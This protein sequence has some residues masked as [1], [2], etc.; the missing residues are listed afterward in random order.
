MRL[1][2]VWAA[3]AAIISLVVVGTPAFALDVD[4]ANVVK[5]ALGGVLVDKIFSDVDK[6]IANAINQVQNAGNGLVM[7]AANQAS[8][9]EQDA[10]LLVGDQRQKTFDQLNASEQNLLVEMEQWRRAVDKATG[11]AYDI[12]DTVNLDTSYQLQHLPFTNVPDFFV[13][14]VHGVSFLKQ[15]SDYRVTL[16]ALNLGIQSNRQAQISV[17][18]DQRPLRIITPDQ[19][20]L[21]RAIITIPSAALAPYFQEDHL[22][23]V[24]LVIRVTMTQ[25]GLLQE[26]LHFGSPPS[27]THEVPVT[28]TLYPALAATIALEVHYPHYDWISIGAVPGSPGPPTPDKNGCRNPASGCAY[29]GPVELRV[30]SSQSTPPVQGDQRINAYRLDCMT[31][32]S[33]CNFARV[34]SSQL[35]EN[36]SHAIMVY[37]TWSRPVQMR[38]LATAVSEYR[39]RA[40]DD[41]VTV[42][43]GVYFDHTTP[44]STP[45]DFDLLIAHVTTFTGK[46]YD[47]SPDTQADPNGLI[48]KSAITPPPALARLVVLTA[49]AP[50]M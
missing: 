12:I 39:R 32:T 2:L 35:I 31:A 22:R 19:S 28:L 17:L 26:I 49:H 8:V 46:T 7:H 30:R 20:T 45:G 29:A 41:V 14:S 36:S 10:N 13:Q 15:P 23:T 42:P 24:S 1:R 25:T 48:L 6:T 37:Q 21:N 34:T 16:N 40:Q 50:P 38:V 27:T 44:V 33:V 9:L 4:P 5:S 43:M 18:L 47:F 11:V 3:A